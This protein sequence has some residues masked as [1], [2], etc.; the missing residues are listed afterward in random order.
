MI[1]A[2]CAS[3]CSERTLEFSLEFVDQIAKLGE[4]ERF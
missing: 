2:T 1:S 4:L 3:V